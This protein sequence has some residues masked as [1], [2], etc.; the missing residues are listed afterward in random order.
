MGITTDAPPFARN[1]RELRLPGFFRLDLTVNALRRLD[2]NVVDVLTPDHRYLRAFDG[3]R[4]TIVVSVRQAGARKLRIAIDGSDGDEAEILPTIKR[5]LGFD[6][7]VTP[8]NRGAARVPWL[9][10]LAIRMRGIKPP[11]YPTLWEAFVNGIAFQQLSL[12]AAAAIVGRLVV[13][14]QPAI[15]HQGTALYSFPTPEQFLGASERALRAAGLSGNKLA[16]L[17]R[18]AGAIAAGDLDERMLKGR[19]T[20]DCLALLGGIKG[21]GPWTATIVLLR[22]LGRLDLFPLNDTSVVQNLS[23][24]PGA[25]PD[26][27]PQALARLRP[28]QG[29]LYYHLL[30]ARLE[31]RG[32]LEA[33]VS[34]HVSDRQRRSN[35]AS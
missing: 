5:M 25:A 11:R 16:A 8:F 35:R 7:D 14:L 24:L 15:V 3:A 2:T 30:L 26:S 19:S 18:V 4:G 10:A 23:L 28:Q 17:R 32:A 13:A 1:I 9:R 33:R 20:P 22:G 21:V 27:L 34:H 12:H 6:C 31:S 29:M